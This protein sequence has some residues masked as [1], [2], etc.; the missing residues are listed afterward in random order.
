MIL[1]W[2]RWGLLVLAFIGLAVALGFA[3]KEVLAPDL[4]ASSSNT[5]L[6]FGVG[7]LLAGAALWV[8]VTYVFPRIDP[9]QPMWVSE[10]LAEPIVNEQGATVTHK[11]VAI[12]DEK[13]GKQAHVQPTSSLFYIPIRF[14]PYVLAVIGVFALYVGISSM[15][16]GTS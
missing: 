3:L 13:T 4:R 9:P 10:K 7:F 6:Y 14:W 2:S 1:I 5:A 12:I 16:Q 15:I 11:Q 8:F